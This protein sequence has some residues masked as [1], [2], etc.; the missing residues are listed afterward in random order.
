M[1]KVEKLAAIVKAS[2]KLNSINSKISA[3][4]ELEADDSVL[5]Q[6]VIERDKAQS[7]LDSLIDYGFNDY[8]DMQ[9]IFDAACG[10]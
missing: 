8:G 9:P 10:Q 3:A 2:L 4:D 7:E 1:S 5:T 6:L